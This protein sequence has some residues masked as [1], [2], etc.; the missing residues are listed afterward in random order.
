[1]KE[2]LTFA[3]QLYKVASPN[4]LT[5]VID[6]VLSS[7]GLDSCAD[8]RCAGLSGGQKRRLSIAIALLKQPAVLFLDE[9]TSGLDSAS[10]TAVAAEMQ[11]VARDEGVIVVCTIHQPSTV[12]YSGFDQVMILSRGREAFTGRLPDAVPYFDSIGYPLPAATN[13]SEH[14]LDIVNSDFSDE[15]EVRGILDL[16][17]TRKAEYTDDIGET[18]K[19]LSTCEDCGLMDEV[20][21]VFKRQMLLVTRD[22]V[23]Y[24]GRAAIFAVGTLVFALVYKNSRED[25][26][27]QSQNKFWCN[28]KFTGFFAVTRTDINSFL[29]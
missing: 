23:L 25:T 22:P 10:S 19:G 13:P 18:K 29:K 16:W 12:V 15:D 11:R 8:V 7:M 28:S 27:S 9:P 21:I 5:A 14:F 3:A 26:Q 17:Q 20:K 4:E 24:I 1:M 6:G 2:S